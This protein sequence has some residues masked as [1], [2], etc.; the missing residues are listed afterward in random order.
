MAKHPVKKTAGT[1][2]GP[3]AKK[4][5]ATK[6]SPLKKSSSKKPLSDKERELRAA[7]LIVN[8]EKKQKPSRKK[9]KRSQE[10]TMDLLDAMIEGMRDKKAK[11]IMVMDLQK[12]ENRVTDFFVICDAESKTHVNSIADGVEE[13]IEKLSGERAYHSEGRQNGEW[14]LL[15]YINVVGHVFLRE[16]REHY[17]IEAL[18]GD[19]AI[20]LIND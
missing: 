13:T 7:N 19:A 3:P 4:K 20:R 8:S 12:L 15:D 17:N 9:T 5:S 1:A 6:S 18:W 14:I 2:K 16:A 11:N 10:A